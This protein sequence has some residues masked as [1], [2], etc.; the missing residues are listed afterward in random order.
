MTSSAE[1]THVV[2][3]NNTTQVTATAGTRENNLDKN[4]IKVGWLFAEV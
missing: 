3:E 4:W 2:R 1:E